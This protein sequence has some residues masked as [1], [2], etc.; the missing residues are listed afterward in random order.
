MTTENIQYHDIVE[1]SIINFV[2]ELELKILDGWQ[3][4][5][6]NPGDIIGM[7]NGT[8]TVSLYRNDA[9][10]ER[11]KARAEGVQVRPKLDRAATLAKAR[12]AKAEKKAQEQLDAGKQQQ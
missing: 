11:L 4:S 8:F 12:A 7:W 5:K 1:H 2:R 9:S 6:T 3:V 10:I